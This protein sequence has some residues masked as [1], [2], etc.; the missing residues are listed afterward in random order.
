MSP[1][2]NPCLEEL[3]VIEETKKSPNKGTG[4]VQTTFTR[5]NWGKARPKR[6]NLQLTEGKWAR[7]WGDKEGGAP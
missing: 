3:Q 5:A 1:E 7:T 6:K 4:T 2:K